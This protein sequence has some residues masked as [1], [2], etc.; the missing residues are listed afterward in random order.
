M[1]G[2][3]MIEIGGKSLCLVKDKDGEN[4]MH[5]AV[6]ECK[7]PYLFDVLLAAGGADLVV[8]ENR[9]GY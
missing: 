2:K 1:W 3:N 8:D 6:V 5:L 9:K 4:P 7:H